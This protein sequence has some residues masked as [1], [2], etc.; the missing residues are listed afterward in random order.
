MKYLS[1]YSH[2]IQELAR[3]QSFELINESGP[4]SSESDSYKFVSALV[5]DFR[6]M[7]SVGE[8]GDI[9]KQIGRIEKLI[10]E[11]TLQ[12]QRSTAKLNNEKFLTNAPA[13]IVEKERERLLDCQKTL[14]ELDMRYSKLKAYAA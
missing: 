6:I 4:E 11:Q 2:V 7:L 1:K 5:G 13:E 8:L 14:V 12:I 9:E 3:L 10:A